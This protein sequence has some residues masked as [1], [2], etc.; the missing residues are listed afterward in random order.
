M[1]NRV[2]LVLST[3]CAVLFTAGVLLLVPARSAAQDEGG[4]RI[5]EE[6]LR[7]E[8]DQMS[9][10]AKETG[11]DAG[12]WFNFAVF[13]FDDIPSD[14]SR[15]LS[16]YELRGWARANIGRVHSAYLRALLRLDHWANGDNLRAVY[17]K[18]TE[19][20]EQIERAWYQFDL[21]ALLEEQEG[22]RL[23]WGLKVKVGRQYA[24][25]GT[26]LALSMPLDMVRV[27]ARLKEFELQ[28]FIGQTI[29]KSS[30][31][32]DLSPLV[33]DRQERC[34]Y[35]FQVACRAG[36]HRPFAY[37]F[38]QEDHTTPNP[39]SL[40]QRY[41]YSSRYLGIG[42]TGTLLVPGLTYSLEAVGEWGKTFGGLATDSRD[43][44]CA[45]AMDAAVEYHFDVDTDPRVSL[46]YLFAG[47]DED[48]FFTSSTTFGGNLTGTPDHAFN[49]F[50]YRDTGL[51]FAPRMSN[52]HICNAGF[53]L[54]PLQEI[55]FF[56][57]MEVGTKV[58]FYFRNRSQGP[59]SE[60]T[61][62]AGPRWLGWEWDVYCDWRI[63]SD[64]SW[65]IRYG[66]F[67]PGGAFNGFADRNRE[68]LYTGV[69]FSF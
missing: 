23:P 69:S 30:N 54:F 62:T 9:P 32:V 10:P 3:G 21:G 45:W 38:S 1:K 56:R 6:D 67:R 63:T 33:Y 29:R 49:G 48:R 52:L 61:A 58:F 35:G 22:Q 39:L 19:I 17:A 15:T 5:Y 57:R 24:K 44:I 55:D 25:L 20:D 50:G 18:D 41:D 12:G 68:F 27:D 28:G 40:F 14:R 34:F 51:S 8:L 11:F 26:G 43:E 37:F 65:T 42:S 60:P 46:E 16:Q 7:V 47:G 2:P 31:P 4:R 64:L 53:S 13:S 36:Q 59:I 66:F